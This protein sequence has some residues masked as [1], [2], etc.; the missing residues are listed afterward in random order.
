MYYLQRY[1][2]A[3]FKWDQTENYIIIIFLITI[4][5]N[6]QFY[7][8]VN[9][10]PQGRM[11]KPWGFWH[12][13]I[14]L[15]S[16]PWVKV[17][18]QNPPFSAGFTPNICYKINVRIP[19]GQNTQMPYRDSGDCR[20][21]YMMSFIRIT[22]VAHPTPRGIRLTDVLELQFQTYN[23]K[24]ILMTV[25]PDILKICS[26]LTTCT[27]FIDRTFQRN[28]VWF[29]SMMCCIIQTQITIY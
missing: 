7:A 25:Y 20:N 27:Q 23:D 4:L 9:V 8:P 5:N 26:Y 11:C 2:I 19:Q 24:C 18:Y 10:M 12:I 1:I 28:A 15:E 6:K 3:S 17:R 14:V 29:L 21:Y 13:K 22:R 16:P